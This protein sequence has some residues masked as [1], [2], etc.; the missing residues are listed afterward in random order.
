MTRRPVP[1]TIRP[2]P[3]KDLLNREAEQRTTIESSKAREPVGLHSEPGV[4]K[5]VLLLRQLAHVK[6]STEYPGGV[7]YLR[8]RGLATPDLLQ[9]LSD[10]FYMTDQPVKPDTNEI[11]RQLQPIQALIILDDLDIER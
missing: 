3:F 10:T 8:A 1:V 2:R 6:L 7:I 5:T 4:G 9:S 11:V